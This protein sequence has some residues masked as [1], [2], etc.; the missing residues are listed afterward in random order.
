MISVCVT[1]RHSYGL[2]RKSPRVG[3]TYDKRKRTRLL[4]QV[5]GQ[6]GG[7][8][9]R[10]QLGGLALTRRKESSSSESI[11]GK[12]EEDEGGCSKAADMTK[13]KRLVASSLS[14]KL[15]A[16]PPNSHKVLFL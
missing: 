6:V 1:T 12:G 2:R 14:I 10:G 16:G 11:R 8:G 3:N 9:C 7:V 13:G 15:E 4:K 5:S